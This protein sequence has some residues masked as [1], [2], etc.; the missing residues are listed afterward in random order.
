MDSFD[1]RPEFNHKTDDH[2]AEFDHKTEASG[3]GPLYIYDTTLRDGAQRAGISFSV[4]DKVNIARRLDE[5]GIHY[6][7][8]GWPGSNPKDSEFFEILKAQPLKK[9][10]LVS[11]G[12]TRRP[13][14]RVEDDPSLQAILKSETPACAIVGKSSKTHVTLGL[15]TTPEENLSMIEESIR[16]AKE[17]GLT[18]IFDAEHFF[19]GFKEDPDYALKTLRAAEEGGADFVTLCDTNGGTLPQE[20]VKAVEAAKGAISTRLGIH[21]H[22]DIG[23]AIANTLLAVTAG[24]SLIQ[25]TINGYGERCGNADLIAIIPNLILKMGV[26]SLDH[27]PLAKITDLARYV[28]EI[29]NMPAQ[30]AQPYAGRNA[31]THKAG[32]HVSA[33]MRHPSTYEH[34]DPARVGNSRRILVSEL[35]G[36]SNII[37]WL[38]GKA[39]SLVP[40]SADD[41]AFPVRVVEKVKDLEYQGYQF[42]GAQASLELMI[43]RLQEDYKPPFRLGSYRVL[44]GKRESDSTFAEATVSVFIGDRNVHTASEGDGPVNAL[45]KALRKAL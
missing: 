17:H 1:R 22:D 13:G 32:I 18:V 33:L 30:D 40:R 11:F 36:K 19:D 25:G 31:F 37:S 10:I 16:F 26:R 28:S 12:S 24:V 43:L 42:E 34:V 29:A 44:V 20:V 8:G 39:E 4:H 14:R 21:A 35:S 15:C 3:I 23:V 6:V 27:F 41:P 5:F 2:K 7:E 45:D 9:S 38:Q